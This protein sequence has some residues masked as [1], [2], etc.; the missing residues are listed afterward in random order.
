MAIPLKYNLRNLFVRRV[1]TLMTVFTVALVVAVFI[2]I[3]SLANGLSSALVSTGAV[4]NVIVLRDGSQTEIQ[5]TVTREAFQI[6]QTL[7]GVARD[8]K[9]RPLAS[10]ETAVLVN[11]PRRGTGQ[12]SNVTIRGVSE[13]G[14][15][16][17]PQ[18]KL[19]AGRM[20]RPGLGEAIVSRT[21][22]ERFESTAIGETIHLGR[23]DWKVVGLF[24][25]GGTAFDSEIWADVNDVG[26]AFDRVNYSS[27]LLR[28]ENV[29]AR[30]LLKDRIEA[31]QRLK[32]EA[33]PEL[34]YY[35][36]QTSAG[37]PIKAL[38]IF[39]GVILG[40]GACFGGMNTM[41]AAVAF[42][43]R[44]IGTLRA[45][46]F[47][48]ASILTSFVIESVIIALIGGVVGCVL[49]IPFNGVAT[50]TTN[51]RTFSELA[52]S[53]RI[54]PDLVISALIFAAIMGVFGGLLPSRFA[55]RMPITKALRQM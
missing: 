2:A 12:P 20:L 23:R 8:S 42:R 37:G 5:S 10:A 47:S 38:G 54:T 51:F 19:V 50:G 4:E 17:R 3:M 40:I 27:A 52:F 33:K 21:I 53:F 34:K 43:T 18:V 49:S 36:E 35:E 26:G 7:P 22:S 28:A 44:E 48:K 16:M 45:L 30:D 24:D 55:A 15:A 29:A 1:T 11:L 32:L 6:I 25:A 9:G 31:E 39:V 46:G 13:T 41:Y 14:F